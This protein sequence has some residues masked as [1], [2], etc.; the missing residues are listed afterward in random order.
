M[1]IAVIGKNFGDEGKGLVVA[2]LCYNHPGSLVIKHNGGAQ[3]GHTVET[4][5]P[6]QKFIHHQ[7]GSGAR[8]GARTFFCNTFHPDL[9]QLAKEINQFNELFGFIPPIYAE[10]TVSITSIDDVILNMAVES[11]RGDNRHGSCGMGINECYERNLKGFILSLD[12]VAKEDSYSL[13]LKLLTFRNDYSV[14]RA[15][16]LGISE[17]NEY[18]KLLLDDDLL[19]NY[20]IEIKNNISYIEIVRDLV[21]FIDAFD[22]VIFESGQGLML[23]FDRQE[24]M[25]YLTPSKT[26]VANPV[27]FLSRIGKSLDEVIYVSRTYVTRHG[28]G[29]LPGEVIR[30]EL[31]GVEKDFT[32]EPN[33][34]QGT[35][36]YGKHISLKD[37]VEPLL[38]DC[39]DI[40]AEISL[41]L[42]HVDETDGI[43]YF[44]DGNLT[45]GEVVD[46]L[47]SSINHVYL[48]KEKDAT[49]EIF[50][51]K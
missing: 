19:R 41:V 1:N 15:K 35:I 4:T 17:D 34:W 44:E 27:N 24:Y 43:V 9:F 47:P 6:D 8:F 3:A 29:P 39:K 16:E 32:N 51:A 10:A 11:E 45:V 36:R 13:Y 46:R 14:K 40:K 2:N 5:T 26:G 25:P 38:S 48:S 31:E 7:I 37:F 20:A 23:D 49:K 50:V 30:N 18:Y 12:E 22:T 33:D 42:T 28:A 21:D